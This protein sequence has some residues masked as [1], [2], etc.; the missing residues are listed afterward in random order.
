MLKAYLIIEEKVPVFGDLLHD[1][2]AL[3]KKAL[4]NV[5]LNEFHVL[6]E[7]LGFMM[8]VEHVE[9]RAALKFAVIGQESL[10]QIDSYVLF[11]V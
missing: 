3:H 10:P 5:G 1:Y 8:R 4:E 9:A 6:L 7:F 11:L 2:H